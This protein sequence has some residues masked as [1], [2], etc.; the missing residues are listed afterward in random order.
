MVDLFVEQK[1]KKQN[2]MKKLLGKRFMFLVVLLV[3]LCMP[4][5]LRAAVIDE[6]DLEGKVFYIRNVATGLYLKQGGTWGTHAVEGRAAHPFAL[7]AWGGGVYAISS[8]N[9][10]LSS[11]VSGQSDVKGFFME[12]TNINDSKWKLVRA[13]TTTDYYYIESNGRRF[14][15][16][17]HAS[18]QIGLV[19]PDAND[20][21]Q[22]W[23]ILTKGEIVPAEIAV[24]QGA[25]PVSIDV[26]ALID[27]SSF[28]LVDGVSSTTAYPLHGS[29]S[30]FATKVEYRNAAW[31]TTHND[32]ADD[33]KPY[34]GVWSYRL[35]WDARD[36]DP[37]VYNSAFV[38]RN[39]VHSAFTVSQTIDAKLPA[40]KYTFTFEG[41]YA[42]R[43]RGYA[44]D[45]TGISG[46]MNVYMK[47]KNENSELGSETFKRNDAINRI[48]FIAEDETLNLN[49]ASYNKEAYSAVLFRD[50][51]NWLN[52]ISFTIPE[53]GSEKIKIEI[54]KDA[55]SEE[56]FFDLTWQNMIAC[57][58]LT[59]TYHGNPVSTTD[60]DPAILYYDRVR[61]AYLHATTELYK[62]AGNSYADACAAVSGC[63][64]WTKWD[65]AISGVVTVEGITNVRGQ[66]PTE[67]DPAKK[68]AYLNGKNNKIDTE[69]E[70][71]EALA[72]IEEA[73]QA[74]LA[75]HNGHLSDFTGKIL[76][77]SFE[78]GD[79][80]SWTVVHTDGDIAV[81]PNS[82]GTYTTAGV[83]GDYL[84]NSY[85]WPDENTNAP[86]IM[87][88]VT[89][90]DNG[91]YELKALVTSFG[92]GER[93]FIP[94]DGP[95]N[96]VYIFANG[97]H[98]GIEAK[99][100]STFEE[101]ILYFLV[102][103]GKATIGAVGGNNGTRLGVYPFKYYFPHVGCFFKADNFRLTRI[104][105][106]P[107][108]KLKLALDEAS[109]A[110]LAFD[111]LGKASVAEVLAE[112]KSI[113]DDRIATA[114]NVDGYITEIHT[115]LNT[116]AKQQQMIGADMT[117]AIKN[118]N[119]EWSWVDGEWNHTSGEDSGIIGGEVL[120]IEPLV[121]MDAICSIHGKI[122]PRLCL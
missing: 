92:P 101:A 61:A 37:M 84:F 72:K 74:A 77:H 88:E 106:V 24:A 70:F 43:R 29:I 22:Q 16:Q 64:H 1:N 40:G 58:N 7:E 98:T 17:S 9:G 107:N 2:N 96:T 11:T 79:L 66:N 62:L 50:N 110:N 103:D 91:L 115:A 83:D 27:G 71:L 67:P 86:G 18:G 95:G 10:Y 90:L 75:E 23:Q 48:L 13:N 51:D 109:E 4:T 32:P 39:N 81:W 41:F 38:T 113:Y 94:A 57:D 36:S 49:G 65:A 89:G 59:L 85:S 46:S 54:S 5:V 97:Y 60:T 76:N 26:T 21:R 105:D 82:N 6:G 12:S 15:S 20:A 30:G 73:Y 8:I 87:Q 19:A 69:K 25:E 93:S 52:S 112:Y 68:F 102:E 119:F 55:T 120:H 78:T 45:Q 42:R 121:S 53:G 117:Y 56:S 3:G 100:L 33:G 114:A 35:P 108:G 104:C 116:A 118:P 14:A 63:V 122:T 44:W 34:N 28:D 80:T 111:E 31:S 99:S 47:V